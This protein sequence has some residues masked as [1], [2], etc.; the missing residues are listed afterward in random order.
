VSP[1]NP[2]ASP[3][4]G[5]AVPAAWP[6]LKVGAVVDALVLQMLADGTARI[7]TAQG[8]M[9]GRSE[10]A[11]TPGSLVRLQ[12]TAPGQLKL[13]ATLAPAGSAAAGAAVS[14]AAAGPGA[15][16]RPD[17]AARPQPAATPVPLVSA[18]AQAI[19]VADATR[20]A[21][22]QQRGLAPLIAELA[23]LAA[24]PD[25]PL[26]AA[27]RAAAA[28][29]LALPL[30]AEA[31]DAAALR[32]AFARSGLFRESQMAGAAAMPAA[33]AAP[34]DLKSALLGLRDA[35]QG[36]RGALPETTE[37]QPPAAGAPRAAAPRPNGEALARMVAQTLTQAA[38][39]RALGPLVAL[40]PQRALLEAMAKEPEPP[41]L[42]AQAAVA[43]PAP[44]EAVK[45]PPYRHGPLSPQPAAESGL[46]PDAAPEEV[47]TRLLAATEGALARQTL[48]QIASLPEAAEAGRGERTASF[49]FELPLRTPE[50]AVVVPFEIAR[51]GGSG[52]A[53]GPAKATAWQA[54]F[55]TDLPAVGPVHAQ[56]SLAGERA[57]VT[58]WAEHADTAAALR[59]GMPVLAAALREAALEPGRLA[60]LLGAPRAPAA[61]PGTF[62]DQAT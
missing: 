54:R 19:A 52:G 24:R 32:D 22:G 11:L 49:T 60:I 8:P 39:P 40:G 2:P 12:A 42:P 44:T 7:A 43:A 35:L 4:Q 15:A 53:G 27:V 41:S 17:A 31:L 45:P 16:G 50:G 29:V 56:V 48:T 28:A 34:R 33:D 61:G 5:I 62:L 1:I 30:E 13:V 55:S 46:V 9:Q 38:D 59:A 21:S 25:N 37:G 6:A 51:D 3:I 10:A 23:A 26:P 58:L 57:S 47:A 14:A 20:V 36:W 18:E